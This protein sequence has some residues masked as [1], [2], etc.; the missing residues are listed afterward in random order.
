MQL[1]S[2]GEQ[3]IAS[4]TRESCAKQKVKIPLLRGF[5]RT[6]LPHLGVKDVLNTITH[7]SCAAVE[8][9]LMCGMD[10][11]RPTNWFVWNSFLSLSVFQMWLVP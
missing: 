11:D 6:V 2:P 5:P 7:D 8:A 3:S 10:V 9:Q 1:L 4:E